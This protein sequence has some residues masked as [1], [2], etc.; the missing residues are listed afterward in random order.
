MGLKTQLSPKKKHGSK[1]VECT[2][3]VMLVI[4][5]PT[6]A[7]SSAPSKAWRVSVLSPPPPSTVSSAVKVV[8]PSLLDLMDR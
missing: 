7:P 8:S 4:F 1:S 6:P 3:V 2:M 5:A